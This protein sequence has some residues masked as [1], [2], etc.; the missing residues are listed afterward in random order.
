MYIHVI[1]DSQHTLDELY[2]KT[3]LCPLLC[4]LLLLIF[5]LPNKIQTLWNIGTL[6][7]DIGTLRTNDRYQNKS[8]ILGAYYLKCQL[9]RILY[10]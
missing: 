9:L 5:V 3:M 6:L 10:I 8:L 7:N 1:T 2:L 4:Y